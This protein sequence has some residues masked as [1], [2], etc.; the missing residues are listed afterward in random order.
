M[1]TSP[2]VRSLHLVDLE[3]LLGDPRADAGTALAMFDAFL[4]VAH[5]HADDHVIVATNPWLMTKI[6][7]DLPIPVSPHAAHGHD[8]ADLMLL[9]LASAELVVKR[10]GR[11][12]IGSGDGIFASRARTVSD[13][14]VAVEVVA[15]ADGCSTRLHRFGCSY[16]HRAGTDVM[17][18]A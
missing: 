14:G 9:S 18:A 12:V 5:W 10:Y 6:A 7:F 2:V 16:L 11:L 8:G 13:Q 17:L 3:N 4:D 15:R 1:D